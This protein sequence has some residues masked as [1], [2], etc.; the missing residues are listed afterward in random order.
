VRRT[1]AAGLLALLAALA[2]YPVVATGYGVRVV[3]QIFMWIAL[4]GSWNL[5]SGLTGY[6]SF[7]HVAFFGAGA[8]AGGLLVAR[9]AL[10]LL[11]RRRGCAPPLRMALLRRGGGLVV[12]RRGLGGRRRLL[13]LGAVG[14][15]LAPVVAAAPRHSQGGQR[16]HERAARADG[17]EVRGRRRRL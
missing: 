15:R 8:Y 5:I 9:A 16:Q 17:A 3:Q 7:G 1:I 13:R 6:V 12:A 10:L 14:A 2:A 4:A 11:R